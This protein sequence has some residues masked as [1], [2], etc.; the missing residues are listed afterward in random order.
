MENL[1]KKTMLIV[2]SIMLA[3]MVA[4]PSESFA[5][6]SGGGFRSSSRRTT[7]TRRSTPRK[8]TTKKRV[9]KKTVKKSTVKKTTKKATV[10]KPAAKTTK[11]STPAK[12]GWSKSS[13][14]D[15]SK[16]PKNTKDKKAYKADQAAYQKAKS[17]GK[18]FTDKKSAMKDFK[19]KNA[20]KYT[21]K[22]AT[23][24]TTRPAHVPSTY[25][26]NGVNVNVNY[27]SSLG[28]YGYYSGG[29]P[30]LGT[31]IMYD[32]MLDNARCNRYMA[33][34]GYYVGTPMVYRSSFGFGSP[35]LTFLFF[36]VIVVIVGVAVR[37][38]SSTLWW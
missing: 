5:R 7:T 33:N 18:S 20:T 9:Q 16:R 2:A 36:V 32:M 29:G 6:R 1:S 37:S 15:S 26:Y 14:V 31:L 25:S 11:K 34:Q 8:S 3:V 13:A 4:L 27:H 19:S 10:A 24:P 35:V 28:G 22:Y 12:K 21:S 30:G 23:K 38:N 17:S